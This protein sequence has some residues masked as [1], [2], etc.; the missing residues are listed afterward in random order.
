M[1]TDDMKFNADK[2]AELLWLLAN[3]SRLKVLDLIT[4]DE[5]GVSELATEVG[6]SQSALSQH[7]ARFRGANLVAVRR[8]AQ[9]HYYSCS[10]QDILKVMATLEEIGKISAPPKS[11]A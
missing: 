9:N 1:M 3:P 10:S 7:L 4:K 2:A 5:W 11:A 8:D 6:L